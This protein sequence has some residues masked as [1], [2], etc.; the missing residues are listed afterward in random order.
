MRSHE[1]CIC[2]YIELYAATA[3]WLDQRKQTNESN[4]VGIASYS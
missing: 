4:F 3:I 1:L 2:I